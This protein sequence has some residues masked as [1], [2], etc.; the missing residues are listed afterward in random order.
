MNTQANPGDIYNTIIDP[1]TGKSHK[2]DTLKGTRI[3]KNYVSVF[4]TGIRRYT[5]PSPLYNNITMKIDGKLS[6]ISTISTIKNAAG[7]YINIGQEHIFNYDQKLSQLGSPVKHNLKILVLCGTINS[8]ARKKGPNWLL[9]E[10]PDIANELISHNIP[11]EITW[12]GP[13]LIDGTSFETD[14]DSSK[15][16]DMNGYSKCIKQITIKATLPDVADIHDATRRKVPIPSQIIPQ[17][18]NNKYDIIINE[19]CPAISTVIKFGVIF[20]AL[21]R[22]MHPDSWF[23]SNGNIIGRGIPTDIIKEHRVKPYIKSKYSVDKIQ[24]LPINDVV[25]E[26]RRLRIESYVMNI[27]QER[28]KFN[29]EPVGTVPIWHQIYRDQL[30]RYISRR[31]PYTL[32]ANKNGLHIYKF[33]A[34]E[35]TS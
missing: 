23:V 9:T 20:V 16:C 10:Y 29:Q 4:K 7:K 31:Q 21:I 3:I 35:F 25:L 34:S 14:S 26:L 5:P 15:E 8:V 11:Y 18:G 1:L 6:K 13:D 32:P 24:T 28:I 17:L 12:I 22:H 27:T 30:E 2:I 33:K 19:L